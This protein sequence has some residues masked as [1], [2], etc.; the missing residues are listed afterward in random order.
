M[1][2]ARTIQIYLPSGDSH[3]IRVAELK[4][5]IGRLVE[6]SRSLPGEFLGVLEPGKIAVFFPIGGKPGRIKSHR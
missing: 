5:D 6:V 4:P 2:R 3:S 1:P